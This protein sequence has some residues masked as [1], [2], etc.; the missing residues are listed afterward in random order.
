[1]DW[2]TVVGR[3][4]IPFKVRDEVRCRG[5][6]LQSLSSQHQSRRHTIP[7]IRLQCHYDA[8]WSATAG[9]S[10]WSL[11]SLYILFDTRRRKGSVR[12]AFPAVQREPDLGSACSALV[13]AVLSCNP[14]LCFCASTHGTRRHSGTTTSKQQIASVSKSAA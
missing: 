11:E 2:C 12:T 7:F 3:R 13:D 1:M 9:R 10:V 4:R 14:T 8:W 5:R 6:K